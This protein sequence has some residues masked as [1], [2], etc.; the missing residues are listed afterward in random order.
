MKTAYIGFS[1][2]NGISHIGATN[3]GIAQSD[4]TY[5]LIK[6]VVVCDYYSL[7]HTASTQ[8]AKGSSCKTLT[9]R[10]TLIKN[11]YDSFKALFHLRLTGNYNNLIFYHSFIFAPLL[12]LIKISGGKYCLQVNEIFSL[13][14][15]HTGSAH[16]LLEKLILKHASAY[17]LATESLVNHV[18]Y[19][20]SDISKVK[21]FIS[22]PI[23]IPKKRTQKSNSEKIKIVYTGIVDTIKAGAMISIKLASLLNDNRYEVHIYGFGNEKDVSLLKRRIA[24]NNK[25]SQTKVTFLGSLPPNELLVALEKYDYGLAT[26]TID[27]SFAS[28]SFPSKILTYLSG[29]VK[30]LCASNPPLL[31]W[32]YNHLVF[33]YHNED[34][35]DLEGYLKTIKSKESINLSEELQKIQQSTINDLSKW[36]K[37]D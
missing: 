26:Q 23:T 16:A 14:G 5:S 21:T 13:S 37:H 12:F 17:I 2:I 9:L 28:T 20:L 4:Y 15:S 8:T 22:G 6:S 24:K 29:G 30:P 7:A 3:A 36:L 34:L 18:T 35:S 33:I 10:T 32:K 25:S 19:K 27:A 31:S 1:N 11:I